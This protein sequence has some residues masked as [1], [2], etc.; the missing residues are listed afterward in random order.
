[1]TS[2]EAALEAIKEATYTMIF[3]DHMMP[4]M[5]GLE[6][7]AIIRQTDYKTPIIAL[8]ANAINGVEEMFIA[9][10]MDDLL[11]K[12]IEM[13]KLEAILDKWIPQKLR[14]RRS[15]KGGKLHGE[16]PTIKGVDVNLGVNRTGGTLKNYTRVLSTFVE[17]SRSV[18]TEL[19]NAVKEKNFKLFT[20]KVH[21]LKSSTANIG[22]ISVSEMAATLESAGYIE[23][24]DT[25]T[26]NLP[27]LGIAMAELLSHL[28]PEVSQQSGSESGEPIDKAALCE[29][30]LALKDALDA[31]MPSAIKESIEALESLSMTSEQSEKLRLISG[32]VLTS[33]YDEALEVLEEMLESLQ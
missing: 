8:T 16:F 26:R 33:D 3:M 14:Q 4:G 10:G 6:V 27:A 7:T 21:A 24:T 17:E 20:T 19:K 1:V 12:P 15:V 31:M 9:G 5:D 29:K 2:G 23:D 22:A 32:N 30:A 11:V 28:T 13:R 25:I 18:F